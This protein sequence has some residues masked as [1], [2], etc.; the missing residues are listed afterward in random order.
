MDEV[1][2][3]RLL[4]AFETAYAKADEALLAS[5]VA[6][7]FEWHQHSGNLPAGKV[8]KG[9]V[10]V[11][12]EIRWRQ[13]H[14]KNVHYENVKNHFAHA[15]IVANFRVSGTDESGRRFCAN[16][17]DLYPVVEGKIAKKDTFWKYHFAST[18]T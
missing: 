14:W 10:Q 3:Q 17:V 8:I 9:I 11:C 7:D 6:S 18:A 15:M 13:T 4:A 1:A 16:A 12:A 5:C 2:L